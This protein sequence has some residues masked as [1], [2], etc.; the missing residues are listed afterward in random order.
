MHAVRWPAQGAGQGKLCHFKLLNVTQKSS[1]ARM[2]CGGAITKH[3]T[4]KLLSLSIVASVAHRQHLA[5]A[6]PES[7]SAFL[8]LPRTPLRPNATY[9]SAPFFITNSR[10]AYQLSKYSKEHMS[11]FNSPPSRRLNCHSRV[12]SDAELMEMLWLPD[13]PL[14]DGP[15]LWTRMR[16]LGTVLDPASMR[17]RGCYLDA[18]DL[19]LYSL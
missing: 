18:A 5:H 1:A 6:P 9:P 14:P 12:G 2:H 10:P 11:S 15:D 16:C 8:R 17:S 4:N 7:A 19:K 3:S 13:V